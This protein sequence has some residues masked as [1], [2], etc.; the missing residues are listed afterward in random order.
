MTD[1]IYYW[2]FQTAGGGDRYSGWTVGDNTLYSQ[3]QSFPSGFGTQYGSYTIDYEAYYGYDLSDFHGAYYDDGRVYV[4]SYY[5]AQSGQTLLPYYGT[6]QGGQTTPSGYSGLGTEYDYINLSGA[7]DDF[8]YGGFYQADAV[9][10]GADSIYYF[11]FRAYNGDYWQGYSSGDSTLYQ[12]GQQVFT[13][14][15]YYTIDTEA[16]YGYDLSTLHGAYWEDGRVYVNW[17][18]DGQTGQGWV[19]YFFGLSNDFTGTYA[20]GYTGI[21]QE[22]DFIDRGGF[23]Y[24]DFGYGGQYTIG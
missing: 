9:P 24:D 23:N 7:F 13:N 21:G 20:S 17:A 10:A 2:T 16:P 11:S 5:D 3:F 4:T 19:P 12:Q 14:Y 22:Y 6:G 1:S 8:G 18:V 15:G